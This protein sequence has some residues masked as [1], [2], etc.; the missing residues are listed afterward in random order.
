MNLFPQ[1]K[2]NFELQDADL[3]Y[4][5]QFFKI[6]EANELFSKL[7]TDVPWQQDDIKVYGKIYEQPRLTAL[8]G[9]QGKPY[10]YSNIIMQPHNWSPLIMH[11][12]TEIETVCN[13]NFTTVLLNNYRNGRDS[14]GWHADNEKELGR[15]RK[16]VV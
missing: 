15:D 16:S 11:I 6:A 1:E 8:Y 14:N 7:K 13:E 5:P 4:Y 3:V 2:I 9:N 12:K 10:G